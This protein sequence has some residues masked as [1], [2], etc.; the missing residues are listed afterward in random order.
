MIAAKAKTIQAVDY[1]K[2]G[3]SEDKVM[4]VIISAA[5][6][7]C[8]YDR[9]MWQGTILPA[10]SYLRR[11]DPIVLSTREVQCLGLALIH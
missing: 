7:W 10:K 8:E 9:E 3:D 4:N 1:A 6:M 5:D 2:A 11:S